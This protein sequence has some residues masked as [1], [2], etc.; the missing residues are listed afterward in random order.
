MKT[1]AIHFILITLCLVAARVSA[2]NSLGEDPRFSKLPAFQAAHTEQFSHGMDANWNLGPTGARGWFMF[3]GRNHTRYSREILIRAVEL[4]SPAHGILKRDDVVIGVDGKEFTSDSRTA[5]AKAINEAEVTGKLKLVV[6]RDGKTVALTIP[7]P[8]IGGYASTAPYKCEKSAKIVENACKYICDNF[9]PAGY[10]GGPVGRDTNMLLLLSTGDPKYLDYVRREV[11][12][13]LRKAGKEDWY[14]LTPEKV[15]GLPCWAWSYRNLFLCEYYI[16][17]GDKSVLPL[18]ESI[19]KYMTEGQS[20]IGLWGHGFADDGVLGGYGAVNQVGLICFMSLI[21]ADEIGVSVDERAIE[22]TGLFFTSFIGRGG[23]SY[24]DHET[25]PSASNNGAGGST[26]ICFDLLGVPEGVKWFARMCASIGELD[27][28]HTG[29]FFNTMWTPLGVLKASPM[30][31][32]KFNQRLGWYY[33][34]SRHHTGGFMTQTG[35]EG[36]GA[37]QN[38]DPWWSTGAYALHYTA[39]Y[40]RLRILGAKKESPFVKGCCP[41][42]LQPALDLFWKKDFSGCLGRIQGAD[43]KSY[44]GMV[45]ARAA[46]ANLISIAST[47]KEIKDAVNN[48]D[49]YKAFYQLDG[50]EPVMDSKSDV[51]VSL[52]GMVDKINDEKLME[53]GRLFYDNSLGYRQLFWREYRQYGRKFQHNQRNLGFIRGQAEKNSKPAETNFYTAASVKLMEK[54]PYEPFISEYMHDGGSGGD[55]L[56][57]LFGAEYKKKKAISAETKVTVSNVTGIEPAEWMKDNSGTNEWKEASWPL[58]QDIKPWGKDA[59]TMGVKIMFTLNP[60]DK[61]SDMILNHSSNVETRYYLNGELILSMEQFGRDPENDRIVWLKANNSSLL[62][63]GQ[64]ILAVELT[65]ANRN[66]DVTLNTRVMCRRPDLEGKV[67]K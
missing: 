1:R 34:L 61:I 54:F 8:V 20:F 29:P 56:A 55:L 28:G 2:N 5:F 37:Y 44:Q 47:V 65:I 27:E 13:M 35:E 12:C 41:K 18:I 64:N 36:G 58:K 21:L 17:T 45:L 33:D 14:H 59:K 23:V 51:F 7:L 4:N 39:P 62:H 30:E 40:R 6:V 67:A 31:L 26:A 22:K 11:R 9:D 10:D 15:G 48:G 57:P 19:C 16:R 42:S 25:Y 46:K 38:S 24:G 66:K 50:L 53:T 43:A 49:L 32:V 60:G 3:T 52:K 63:E